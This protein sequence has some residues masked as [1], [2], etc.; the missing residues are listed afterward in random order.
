ME[1]YKITS[2]SDFPAEA[3]VVD[4]GSFP[5]NPIALAWLGGG[6]KVVCCDGAAMRYLATGRI[7]W[8]IVGDCDSIS[9]EVKNKYREIVRPNP[10]QET[11]DQTKSVTYL[12]E[13][14]VRNIVI[15]AATGLREDHTL[16]NISLLIDYLKNGVT[17]RVYTDF[18]VFIPVHD[19]ICFQCDRGT[20]VSIFNFGATGLRAEGLRYPIRDFDSWW[21][22]TLNE[23]TDSRFTI[24]A[25]GYYLLFVNYPNLR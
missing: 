4:A 22:G 25:S 12:A 7:P 17:A 23:T 8:R 20:Q 9:E 15:L 13:R 19:D 14:G 5:E 2:I 1:K 24:H 3:V 16:G 11:N 6:R 21:Q 10:D 18:G